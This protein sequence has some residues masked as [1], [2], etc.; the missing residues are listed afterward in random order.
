MGLYDSAI[1]G[2]LRL[3]TKA[4]VKQAMPD[5]LAQLVASRMSGQLEAVRF[6]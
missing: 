5:P 1:K 4:A 3:A 2:G 6:V